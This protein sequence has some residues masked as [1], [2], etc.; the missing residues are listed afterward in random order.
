MQQSLRYP[1]RDTPIST[2]SPVILSVQNVSLANQSGQNRTLLLGNAVSQALYSD[3]IIPLQ[4]NCAGSRCDWSSYQSVAFCSSCEDAT[5]DLIIEPKHDAALQAYMENNYLGTFQFSDLNLSSGTGQA[6]FRHTMNTVYNVSLGV[7]ASTQFAL[8]FSADIALANQAH[9]SSLS[10]AETIVWDLNDNVLSRAPCSYTDID[11]PYTCFYYPNNTINDFPGPLKA[12]GYVSMAPAADGSRLVALS[13]QRC[14]IT[15]CAQQLSSTVVNGSL[16]SHIEEADFGYYVAQ[17]Q[18]LTPSN[19]GRPLSTLTWLAGQNGSYFQAGPTYGANHSILFDFLTVLN[20]LQGT[21]TRWHSTGDPFFN[22]G[23]PGTGTNNPSSDV[24]QFMSNVRN[25]TA[26]IAQS[27]TNLIQQNGDV[28]V[29]GQVYQS[30]PFVEVRWAWLA[31]PISLLVIVVAALITTMFQTRQRRIPL[32]K[33]SP[34]PLLFNYHDQDRCNVA[35]GAA[36]EAV[37]FRA[38]TTSRHE[39]MAK[40]RLLRLRSAAGSWTFEK[41][42]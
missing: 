31:F 14:V 41:N 22:S 33:S 1:L 10:Y 2:A 20:T 21:T 7:G 4:P 36:G 32:W 27:L 18:P 11:G 13:A 16:S 26:K 6:N 29:R 40:E 39:E 15:L 35:D 12:F 38:V 19:D 23:Q 42:P 25:N 37:A 3:T 24:I 28:P 9:T 34:Y 8:T 5:I 17:E 30:T